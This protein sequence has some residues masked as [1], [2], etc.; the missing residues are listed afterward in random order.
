MGKY[1]ALTDGLLCHLLQFG[2]RREDVGQLGRGA[3]EASR[4]SPAAS[5]A[6]LSQT[7][8]GLQVAAEIAEL[9]RGLSREIVFLLQRQIRGE[10]RDEAGAQLELGQNTLQ[11]RQGLQLQGFVGEGGEGGGG[12]LGGEGGRGDRPG[13]GHRGAVDWGDRAELEICRRAGAELGA[14]DH[15]PLGPL[16]LDSSAQGGD[17]AAHSEGRG[18]LRHGG[19]SGGRDLGLAGVEEPHHQHQVSPG[20]LRQDDV[21]RPAHRLLLRSWN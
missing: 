10:G 21:V 12:P 3:P 9:A 5:L 2:G 15:F 8:Q 16:S 11:H 17:E 14:V 18:N 20:G 4:A 7:R 13:R 19:Q 1:F 6:V